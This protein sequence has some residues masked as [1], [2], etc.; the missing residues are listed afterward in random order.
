MVEEDSLRKTVGPR[1]SLKMKSAPVINRAAALPPAHEGHSRPVPGRPAAVIADPSLQD[2]LFV[3]YAWENCALADWLVRQLTAHGYRVWCDRF[4]MLG[5]ESFPKIIDNAIKTRT[6]RLIA[7]LSRH[8]LQKP[9]PLKE[10]TLALSLARERGVDFMIPLNVD[11]LKPSDL[12]WDYSDLTYVPFTNWAAGLDQLLKAL[13]KLGAPRPL[14]EA[15]GRRVAAE[16]F[17]PQHVIVVRTETLYSNC[18]AFERVPERLYVIE[19]KEGCRPSDLDAL[20]SVWPHYAAN[21]HTIAFSPPH[22]SVPSDNYVVIAQ[23][24]WRDAADVEGVRSRDI[25]SNLLWQAFARTLVRRGLAQDPESGLFYFP[26]GL[27]TKNKIKYCGRSGR[28]TWVSVLGE[29]TLRGKVY[30]YYLAPDFQFRQD[31]GENF[32]AQ[33]K[34][35]VVLKGANGKRLDHGATVAR[36]KHLASSWFNHHWLSRVLAIS[37][38][39]AKGHQKIILLDKSDPVVLSA[40]PISGEV[41]LAIDEASLKGLRQQLA[42]Q[43]PGWEEENEGREET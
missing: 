27:F 28:K 41:G 7:L 17:L 22:P 26:R 31:L 35:R 3:S 40:L 23:P 9:N 2:H 38:F 12:P 30:R 24:L 10:R 14:T 6:F 42:A 33:L 39:L 11:G 37:S 19:W 32:V 15:E 18:F 36:R 4:K 34:I 21:Q 43:T 29:K 13:G 5:G 20:P 25:V 1:S 16:T 8:S